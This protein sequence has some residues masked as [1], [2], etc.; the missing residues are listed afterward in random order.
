MFS[1]LL[2][3]HMERAESPRGRGEQHKIPRKTDPEHKHLHVSD[4]LTPPGW[5]GDGRGLYQETVL[6]YHYG[7]RVSLILLFVM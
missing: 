2:M 1:H 7:M 6:G 3:L 5:H 4:R